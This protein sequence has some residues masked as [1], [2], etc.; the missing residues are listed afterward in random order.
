MALA[1]ATNDVDENDEASLQHA[2]ELL[3]NALPEEDRNNVM[4]SSEFATLAD[5]C[6]IMEELSVRQVVSIVTDVQ[7]ESDDE[8]DAEEPFVA[9]TIT[10]LEA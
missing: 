10:A 2:L 7:V 6:H 4:N 5:E 1:P 8:Q 9:P 3:R